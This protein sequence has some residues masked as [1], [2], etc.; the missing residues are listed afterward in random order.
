MP[1]T[2]Q[3]RKRKKTTKESCR[4]TELEGWWKP[5]SLRIKV[6]QSTENNTMRMNSANQALAI[7]LALILLLTLLLSL[8]GCA[9][10][11]RGGVVPISSGC[12][13]NCPPSP[14]FL[15]ATS[16]DHILAFTINQSTGALG[17]P[18]A[19]AGPNQSL[20]WWPV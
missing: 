1:R 3:R 6:G 8:A 7:A 14:E 12:G 16:T 17:T 10:S 20:G 4:C 5:I 11:F 2:S 18:L 13:N 9:P 19:M 15:Y